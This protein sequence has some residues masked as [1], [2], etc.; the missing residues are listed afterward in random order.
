[1]LFLSR[2]SE[3]TVH[4]VSR[5]AVLLDCFT[6]QKAVAQG[7]FVGLIRQKEKVSSKAF[8]RLGYTSL[9][10]PISSDSLIVTKSVH[11]SVPY[12][13]ATISHVLQSHRGY[14]KTCIISEAHTSSPKH[15]ARPARAWGDVSFLAV[16][17]RHVR[18]RG[19]GH[20]LSPREK[21]AALAE[22]AIV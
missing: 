13:V 1:M 14:W 5:K 21:G 8:L 10:I 9:S 3:M 4:C 15:L 2:F 19:I 11:H 7:N 20:A 17:S 22:R 6:N 12:F 16:Q 18:D